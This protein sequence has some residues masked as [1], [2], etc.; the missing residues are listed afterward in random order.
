[1]SL[2]LS[3]LWSALANAGFGLVWLLP[4]DQIVISDPLP[5]GGR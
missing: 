2:L 1:M 5:L 3:V 4:V